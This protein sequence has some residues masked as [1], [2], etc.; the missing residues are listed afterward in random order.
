MTV[1]NCQYFSRILSG[2]Q[3]EA[4]NPTE[5]IETQKSAPNG[6]PGF[7]QVCPR[8]PA[9]DESYEDKWIHEVGGSQTGIQNGADGAWRVFS[10]KRASVAPARLAVRQELTTPVRIWTKSSLSRDVCLG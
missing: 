5:H 4:R 1:M 9:L 7:I 6:F 10:E 8:T 2:R 3:N